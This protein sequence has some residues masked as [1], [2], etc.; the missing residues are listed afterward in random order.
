MKRAV[1]P[2][3]QTIHSPRDGTPL[4]RRGV[5]RR[6]AARQPLLLSFRG[7]EELFYRLGGGEE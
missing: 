1:S 6:V 7:F 2:A 5:R 3:I 4:S